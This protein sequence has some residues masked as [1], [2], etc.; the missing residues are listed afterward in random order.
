MTHGK[1]RLCIC[2]ALCGARQRSTH[3]AKARRQ[4]VGNVLALLPLTHN[5]TRANSQSL[6]GLFWRFGQWKFS[7]WSS[8]DVGKQASAAIHGRE[9]PK[10]KIRTARVGALLSTAETNCSCISSSAFEPQLVGNSVWKPLPTF[11]RPGPHLEWQN[12]NGPS[13]GPHTF[14]VENGWPNR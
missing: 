9:T 4:A 11:P 13:I 3:C 8:R 10:N 5:A 12:A 2:L 7:V 14:R 1:P 6:P